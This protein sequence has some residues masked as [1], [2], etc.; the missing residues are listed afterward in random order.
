M[1]AVDLGTDHHVHSQFSDDAVSTM[2][3]NVAAALAAGL[4]SLRLVDHVRSTTPW[5]PDYLLAWQDAAALGQDGGLEVL[6]GV[7]AKILDTAGAVDVPP[8]LVV[9]R[10]GVDRVLLADHQVPG[11][12]GPWSPS[13]AR[14]ELDAGLAA[15]AL[16]TMLVEATCAA[17]ERVARAQLAHLFSVLPK[18]GLGEDDV[19]DELLERLAST[20]A[21]TATPVEVN[22]KWA[23]PGRRV[24]DALAAHD[25]R[26]VASTDAHRAED[27]GRY[28]RVLALARADA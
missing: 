5:L 1:S 8:S 11:P 13:R 9:G 21:R 18:V 16:T 25:V 26:L 14:A 12:D 7:E 23:C 2:T 28:A 27:V 19:G 3:D 20:A 6:S 22:E 24:I 4:T 17:M 15:H 10:G